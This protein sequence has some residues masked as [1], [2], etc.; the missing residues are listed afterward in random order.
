MDP[1]VIEA[2]L[3]VGLEAIRHWLKHGCP[4]MTGG[5]VVMCEDLVRYIADD[6]LPASEIRVGYAEKGFCDRGGHLTQ[7][8]ALRPVQ[9]E[10]LHQL[11][12]L[13]CQGRGLA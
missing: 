13:A 3:Y 2:A 9:L 1:L 5:S 10:V 8:A 7:T 6:R 12:R 4:G 11:E